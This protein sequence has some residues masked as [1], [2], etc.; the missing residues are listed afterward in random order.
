MLLKII[1]NTLVYLGDV[2]LA[3][4][5]EG[6]HLQT[7]NRLK[8]KCPFMSKEV[9]YLEYCIDDEGIDPFGKAPSHL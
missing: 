1:N 7:L 2:M 8:Q 3:E 9:E 4:E 5:N 6:E